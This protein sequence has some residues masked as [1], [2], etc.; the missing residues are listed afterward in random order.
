MAANKEGY[1][2]PVVARLTYQA[3]V[4][5][6]MLTSCKSLDSNDGKIAF[7]ACVQQSQCQ[8]LVS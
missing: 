8:D 6:S 1:Q 3:D 4:K 7:N 5:V 2:K